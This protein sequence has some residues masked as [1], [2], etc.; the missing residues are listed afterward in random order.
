MTIFNNSYM[1]LAT[2]SLTLLIVPDI[3]ILTGTPN[4]ERPLGIIVDIY[5]SRMI[6]Y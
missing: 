3:R 6:A 2:N 4:H 1:K 5:D